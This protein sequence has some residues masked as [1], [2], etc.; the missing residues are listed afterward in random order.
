[1]KKKYPGSSDRPEPEDFGNYL[2]I[3][4]VS[5]K[6]TVDKQNRIIASESG[7]GCPDVSWRANKNAGFSLRKYAFFPIYMSGPILDD[8]QRKSA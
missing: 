3:H 8:I 1:L 7:T 5:I 2:M 4:A 6:I